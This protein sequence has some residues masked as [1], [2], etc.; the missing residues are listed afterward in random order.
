MPY[1]FIRK[2]V[3]NLF[4]SFKKTKLT[5]KLFERDRERKSIFFTL[6]FASLNLF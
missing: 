1:I 2:N 3:Q 5:E 6:F 4:S